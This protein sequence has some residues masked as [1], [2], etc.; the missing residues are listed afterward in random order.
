MVCSLGKQKPRKG[1]AKMD[2]LTQPGSLLLFLAVAVGL[3]AVLVYGLWKKLNQPSEL[4]EDQPEEDDRPE[5]SEHSLADE[6]S[7]ERKYCGKIE[8]A[9]ELNRLETADAEAIKLQGT[10]LAILFTVSAQSSV[11]AFQI[12]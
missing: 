2:Q 9:L 12:P 7:G 10:K 3:A 6:D 5:T 1:G 4:D 11:V 8:M